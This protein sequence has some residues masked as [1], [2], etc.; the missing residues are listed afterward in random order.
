MNGR[1]GC[2]MVEGMLN[3][4]LIVYATLSIYASTCAIFPV[5]LSIYAS[6]YAI[7]EVKGVIFRATYA[8][9][10]SGWTIY[11]DS[12]VINASTWAIFRGTW[13]I[14]APGWSICAVEGGMEADDLCISEAGSGINEVSI[15]NLFIFLSFSKVF[16][17]FINIFNF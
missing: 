8:I 1:K 13:T 6:G 10:A 3:D 12:G 9:D 4:L 14:Y 15:K 11:G 16:H 7:G 5:T 17:P 2:M